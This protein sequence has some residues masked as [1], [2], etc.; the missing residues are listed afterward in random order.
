[1][2]SL[3]QLESWK[4]QIAELKEQ[5]QLLD[6]LV[7]NPDPALRRA[8]TDHLFKAEKIHRELCQE[9]VKRVRKDG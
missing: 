5:V 9:Y 6:T 2:I 7:V 3:Q 8:L 1:M 4:D